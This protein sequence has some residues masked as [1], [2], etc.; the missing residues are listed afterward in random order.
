MPTKHPR[1]LV[2]NDPQLADALARVEP[3]FRGVPTATVVHDLALRGAQA[4]ER[5]SK[6]RE[7][8]LQRL[9]AF[10]TER[11]DLIDWE[12]LERVDELAWGGE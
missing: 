5:E 12:I 4:L 1:I 7:A 10:S 2:T 6:E 8:A 11:E 3:Y 9:L